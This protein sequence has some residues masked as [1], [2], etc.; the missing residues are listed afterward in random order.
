MTSKSILFMPFI[1][2]CAAAGANADGDPVPDKSQPATSAS[3]AAPQLLEGISVHG[4]VEPEDYK[5]RDKKPI[6]KLREFLDRHGKSN[7]PV[8]TESTNADG[9]RSVKVTT[10]GR[11]YWVE[12]PS[13][14]IDFSGINQ[15][16]V[17]KNC[18]GGCK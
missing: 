11:T 10:S 14:K 16:K 12:G 6:V 7:L 4:T 9:I 13:G 15:S 18:W 5:K 17:A 8:F 3:A 2:V 1:F